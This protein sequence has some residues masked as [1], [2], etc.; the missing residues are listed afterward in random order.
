MMHGACLPLRPAVKEAVR[1]QNELS[2][3]L[4]LEDAPG[5]V[6]TIAACDV[7]IYGRKGCGQA[8]LFSYLRLDFIEEA[9]AQSRIEFPYVPGLLSFREAPVLLEP[10]GNLKTFPDLFIFGGRGIVRSGRMGIASHAGI[11]LGKPSIG[12]ARTRLRGLR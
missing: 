2:D 11:M 7:S 1:I 6:R 12:C 9:C 5:R 4:I 8:F 3:M 10:I